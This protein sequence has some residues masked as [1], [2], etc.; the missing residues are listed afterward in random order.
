[1]SESATSP[2]RYDPAMMILHWLMALVIIGLWGMGQVM[3]DLPKGDLRAQVF[4]VHK[5]VGMIMLALVAVR[6]AWRATHPQPE[7]PG[8]MGPVERLAAVWGH[9]VL[10]FLMVAMPVSGF[11]MSQSAGFP[12]K[13]FGMAL[14]TL[15]EKSKPLREAAEAAHGAM[16]WVLGILLVAHVAAALRHQ[17]LL[18]DGVLD[19]MR[20]ARS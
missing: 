7:L 1:M 17:Y 11:V 12:V 6:L 8:G 9:R 19:R 4:G 18:R 3:E 14:P 5:G 13:V 15:V 2:T 10:Y 20:P 16:G